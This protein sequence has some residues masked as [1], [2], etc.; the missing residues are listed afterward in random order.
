MLGFVLGANAGAVAATYWH[1]DI[2]SLRQEQLPRW[3]SQAAEK[4]DA[5]ERSI[6][7]A[8]NKVSTQARTRLRR[9][10]GP[11]QPGGGRMTGP[12]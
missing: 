2:D 3:R 4:V 11:G 6:V 10:E 1:R 8:V 9:E 12:S 5:A 7:S